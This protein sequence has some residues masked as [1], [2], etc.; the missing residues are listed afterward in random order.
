[1]LLT[2]ANTSAQI[3]QHNFGTTAISTHPYTAAPSI[4]NPNL[5]GSSWTNSTGTWT[6]AGGA[7]GQAIML[8]PSGTTTITLAFNVAGSYQA[9]ITSFNFWRQRSNSGPQNWSMTINGIPVG[10]GTTPA[11]GSA[12]GNTNVASPV[13]GLTGTVTVVLTLT[14]G[15]GGTFRLDD[16]TLNGSVSSTCA[17]TITSFSPATGPVGT[18]VTVNGS[19]FTGV[20]SVKFDGVPSSNFTI[21]SDSQIRATIPEGGTTGLISITNG[22]DSFSPNGFTVLYSQCSTLGDVYISELYDETSLS[23][24][25]I[26]L[27]N[28]T[29]STIVFNGNYILQ[30]YGNITDPAPGSDYILTLPGSIGPGMTYLI[31][32]TAPLNC[33]APYTTTIGNGF[34]GNDKFELLKN[35]VLIDVVHVPY[36]APGYTIIRKP[37]AVAPANVYNS[38]DWNNFPDE[39]CTNIGSHTANSTAV[40]L[41]VISNPISKTICENGTTTFSASVTPTVGYIYQWKMLNAAGAW[42]NVVNNSIFSGATTNTLTAS[43]ASLSLNNTQYYCQITSAVCSIISNAAQLYVTVA[44]AAPTFIITQPNCNTPTGTVTITNP[45]AGVTYSINGTN[46]TTFLG[47]TP[48]TY[49]ITAE[50]AGGCT[51]TASATIN[52]VPASPLAPTFTIA[53]PTCTI[54]TGTVTITNPVAGVTYS[55]NG[56]NGTTFSGLTPNTYTVT[57]QNA[58]GCTST[59]S[60][61]INAV[62]AAPAAATFTV[63]QPTCTTSTGTVTI[64]NPV[65]GV[66][67]SIN[68]TNGISFP[69]LTPN[70]YTITAENVGGCTSTASATINAVPASPPA[71]TFTIIQPTC[72]TLTGTVTITNP[73]AGLTYSINGTNGTNFSGLTPNTYNITAQNAGGCTSIASATINTVPAAPA[74]PTFTITHPTCNTPTGTVTITNPVAGLTYSING[75]N[76]TT[77]SGLTP[78]TY[79]ITAQNTG[80]CTSTASATVNA[81]PAAPTTPLLVVIQPTCATPSGT[82]TVSPA[83]GSG[84]LSYSLNGGPYQASSS[85]TELPQ[86]QYTITV[87]NGG[88]CTASSAQVTINAAPATA[89]DPGIIIG[90]DEICEGNTTQL[91]STVAGGLWS[92]SDPAIATVNGQGLVTG[93]TAGTVTISYITGT[94]CTAVSDYTLR[95]N[96]MPNPQLANAWLCADSQT[97]N[98]EPKILSSGLAPSAYTFM[99]TKGSTLLNDTTS[100]IIADEPGSYTVTATDRITG[101]AASATSVVGASSIATAYAEVGIDFA[102]NQSI[103][104]HVTGG[105][106]SYE[107]SLNGGPYQTQSVFYN[108]SEGEY[109]VSVRDINGCGAIELEVFALN[110]PRYFTPNGDGTHDVWNIEGLRGQKDS[111]IFIFDRYGKVIT[112]FTPSGYG[113]NGTYNG[114]RLPATDYWFAVEYLNSAG[115]P[116]VFRAHFSLMR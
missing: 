93:L 44:P 2:G 64:T 23:G 49:T 112:A 100:F 16:F 26:E 15:T 69:G 71:P 79:T 12:T 104:I 86:G 83:P 47:L 94:V 52:T 10:S 75:T 106:G 72:T 13:T 77:F 87:Q 41:P 89:P 43:Q 46:G 7:S 29:S 42:I 30:R 114:E 20:S 101:C 59:A 18:M 96:A 111:K 108:I 113:W 62:P 82:I 103:T 35:N 8:N 102:L 56:T 95:V 115:A 33:P 40:P 92:S 58:G 85:F 54:P 90:T 109:I 28:P 24:G 110:Y 98:Y 45:A 9:T 99:W 105:S 6:N 32:G 116:R 36:S 51:S 27:Y 39:S 31:A 73:V 37:S 17:T 65:A 78:N 1:V 107:Y 76:G 14:N 91:T 97:G 66:T 38:N 60:A 74:A 88:G 70:T 53:Q 5:S 50:N 55:I 48:N 11:A 25:M 84:V 81:V 3:Y 19:N 63:T 34:N 22:C 61:T 4:L 21:V 80:G 68:G 57:A 67:Y